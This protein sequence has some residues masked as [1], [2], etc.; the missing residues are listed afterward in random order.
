VGALEQASEK[1]QPP[2]GLVHYSD[3]SATLLTIGHKILMA[4]D[5]RGASLGE[6]GGSTNLVEERVQIQ[7][8]IRA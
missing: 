7:R 3:R 2:P 5:T 8:W 6:L 4:R 1:R